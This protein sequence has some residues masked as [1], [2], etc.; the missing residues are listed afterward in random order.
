VIRRA[1]KL[2]NLDYALDPDSGTILFRGPVAPFDEDLNPIRI[3][4]VYETR[5]GSE[6]RITAGVRV[7]GRP[8]GNVETGATIVHVRRAKAPTT[9]CT[10]S[11]CSGGRGRERP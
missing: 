2:P 6:D 7:V 9:V 1:V 4:V 11:T 5:D 3:V 10:G 8:G